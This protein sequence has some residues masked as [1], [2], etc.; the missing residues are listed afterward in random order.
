MMP[1][2]F[3][4]VVCLTLCISS[5][6]A[7]PGVGI[8]M[9]SRGGVYYTDLKQVWRIS[10]DGKKTL[11]VPGVHTHELYLD[12]DDNLYGEH[13][14]Y[15]GDATGRWGH[16]VWRLSSDGALKDIIPARS[17]F[18]DDY[19]DFHF[20]H[21]ANGNMYW[22]IR[23]ERTMIRKRTPAGVVTT[24]ITASFRDVRWMTAAADGT[25]YLIDR[26]DL[27]GIR[28]D[29]TMRTMASDLADHDRTFLF[30]HN[31]HAVMGLWTDTAGNVYVA[32]A[33]DRLVRRI[34]PEGRIEVVARSPWGWAPTGG[35]LARNG[36]IWLLEDG[37]ASGARAR[38]IDKDGKSTVF[39]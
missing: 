31:R 16:R 25:V 26:Q 14:W 6:A 36:D 23:G 9:D 21:D 12:P 38:R 28:P 32:V 11:A 17:G 3:A 20:V 10:P 37:G 29:G 18:L 24:L 8:V 15:E 30:W 7:H 34:G 35:L 22:A 27:I 13:L 4:V 33:A 19:E 1:R 39:E 5:I 2:A